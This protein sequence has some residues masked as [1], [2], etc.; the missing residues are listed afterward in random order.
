MTD[1]QFIVHGAVAVM[2]AAVPIYDH[3]TELACQQ[4]Q[5]FPLVGLDL[6]VILAM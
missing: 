4:S 2:K 6:S 1:G 5:M 3:A